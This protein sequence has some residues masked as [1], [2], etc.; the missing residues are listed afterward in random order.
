MHQITI[1][2]MAPGAPPAADALRAYF[3]DVVSRYHGRPASRQEIAAAMREDPSHD[4]QPPSGLLLVASHREAVVGCAGL[5]L[6]AAGVGEVT[7]VFVAPGARGHGVGA[8]L[9]QSLER[10]AREYGVTRLQ[11]DTRSDLIEARRL[12]ERHGYAEVAPFNSG[13]YAEHWYAKQ[14]R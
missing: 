6:V 1:A 3:D 2:T 8:R 5:R 13:P 11:L 4:L 12:Y 7:R 9:L 10:H 14:L